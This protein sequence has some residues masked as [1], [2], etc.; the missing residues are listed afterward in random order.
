MVFDA[1]L[2]SLARKTRPQSQFATGQMLQ[3]EWIQFV[4][5]GLGQ[6]IELPEVLAWHRLHEA[7]V[8]NEDSPHYVRYN[9]TRSLRTSNEVYAQRAALAGSYAEWWAEL[10][11]PDAA[12]AWK[13]L[14]RRH[15]SRIAI[16]DAGRWTERAE[17]VVSAA[18][19]GS[20]LPKRFLGLGLKPA[21]KDTASLV[22]KTSRGDSPTGLTESRHGP[23]ADMRKSDAEA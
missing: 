5:L 6:M 11:R 23:A 17:A 12:Y 10:G 18:L 22:M 16:H 3:D 7:S 1:S 8:T 2:L 9:V 19:T 20:Y 4:A 13:V 14:A 15:R 21:L